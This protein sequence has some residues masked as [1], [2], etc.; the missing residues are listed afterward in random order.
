MKRLFALVLTLVVWCSLAPAASAVE[1]TY[2]VPC[3]ESPAFQER[4][5]NSPENYYFNKPY[6]AYAQHELCGP[7]GLPHLPIRLDRAVD[8]AIPFALFFYI[9]GTIGWAGR[10]YL[11][12]SKKSKSPAEKEILI[13]IPLLIQSVV[14]GLLFPVLVFQELASGQL[15]NKD[16][17]ITI[18]PR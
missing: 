14:K 9:T 5:K 6:Q 4:M 17:A 2:L 13:D 18:S 15:T 8:I 7:E 10:A 11:I 16:D 3:S 12:D 1:N